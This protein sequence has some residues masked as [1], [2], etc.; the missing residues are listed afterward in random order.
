MRLQPDTTSSRNT[1]SFFS[2]K[3][4][5]IIGM[6]AALSYILMLLHFPVKYMGFLEI[7]FSD[8]PAIVASFSF[9][10]ATGI[11]IELIKNLIKA[12]TAST[13]GGS[14][15]IAN[16]IVSVGYVLPLGLIFH[17][18]KF[19]HK[20]ILACIAGTICMVLTGIVI[21][22]FITVPLYAKLFGGEEAVIGACASVIPAIQSIGTVVILGI[23]PFNIVKGILISILGVLCYKGIG[24][25]IK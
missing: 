25:Y 9:G 2:T 20:T 6:L 19:K 24:K 22:Y 21:N 17:K 16:F 1:N 12:I 7:E 11:L 14:G 15:E 8:I 18:A 5:V 13:T 10:P 3:Q 4:I 23:T